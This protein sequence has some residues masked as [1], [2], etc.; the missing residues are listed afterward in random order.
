R[1]GQITRN[2][3]VLT[4]RLD[5]NIR[6]SKSISHPLGPPAT[7]CRAGLPA[8]DNHRGDEEGDFVNKARIQQTPSQNAATFNQN[9]LNRAFTKFIHYLDEVFTLTQDFNTG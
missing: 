2:F 9:T 5:L 3:D 1:S 4:S 8:P 7:D 6:Q